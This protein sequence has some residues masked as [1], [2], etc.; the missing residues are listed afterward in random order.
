MRRRVVCGLS[1]TIATLPPQSALTRVDLPTFGRPAIATRPLFIAARR[2][3]P[4][5]LLAREDPTSPTHGVSLPGRRSH[6]GDP[7]A[8]EASQLERVR[9]EFGR[10][11]HH[12]LAVPAGIDHAAD[13]ELDEPLPAP[14][15]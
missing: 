4:T 12:D 14:A 7:F 1:D 15:A 6:V 5:H 10:R 2:P 3:A 9:Q 11:R 8:T 13:A